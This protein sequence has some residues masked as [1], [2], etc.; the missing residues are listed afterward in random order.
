MK[1]GGRRKAK[2]MLRE[3]GKLNNPLDN[4]AEGS[5]DDQTEGAEKMKRRREERWGQRKITCPT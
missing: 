2:L 3:T 4:G 5:A 1:D